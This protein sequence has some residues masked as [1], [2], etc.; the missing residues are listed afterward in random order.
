MHIGNFQ[1]RTT[2]GQSDPFKLMV[3]DSQDGA[4]HELHISGTPGGA[5]VQI[6]VGESAA[7]PW[8]PL[9]NENDQVV[10]VF[11]DIGVVSLPK[12]ARNSWAVLDL[13]GASGTTDMSA[14]YVV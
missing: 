12:P 4:G 9:R 5:T 10:G 1:N 11:T 7:G 8:L 6:L 2:N 3:N 13:A 14:S